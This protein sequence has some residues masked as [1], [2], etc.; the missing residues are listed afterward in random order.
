MLKYANWNGKLIAESEIAINPNNQ[1]FRYGDGCFE[2][3]KMLNSKLVLSTYHFERLYNTLDVLNMQLPVST[4]PT[5][6]LNQIE[7]TAIINKHTNCSKIR[8]TIYRLGEDFENIQK[9]ACYIIQSFSTDKPL[10]SIND[11]GLEMG[12]Y[13]DALKTSDKFSSLKTNNYLPYFMARLWAKKQHLNEAVVCNSFGRIADATIANIF[14]I[15]N[16]IIKTPPLSEG[17]IDGV[18]RRYLVQCIKKDNLPF[19]EERIHTDQLLNAAEVFLS[20]A[21]KGIQWVKRIDTSNYT[22]SVTSFLYNKYINPLFM[23]QSII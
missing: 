23:Q 7:E 21:I 9:S 10:P 2:T 19:R 15:D 6:I 17:C 4:N 3:M 18:M 20:N 22:N 13:K 1:S 8:L 5:H 16:G 14:I 12:I 11:N